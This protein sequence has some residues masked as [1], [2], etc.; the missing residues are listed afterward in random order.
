MID[1]TSREDPK[2]KE[3][4]KVRYYSLIWL[5]HPCWPQAFSWRLR[6]P[7]DTRRT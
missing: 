2:F 3:L 1:P 5:E 6:T 7:A 4:V